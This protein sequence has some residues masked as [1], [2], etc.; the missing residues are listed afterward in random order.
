MSKGAWI[1]IVVVL[2]AG[3]LWWGL[4][5]HPGSPSPSMSSSA[6]P[7]A[8]AQGRAVLMITDPGT[9]SVQG[10]TSIMLTVDKVEVH[11][12]SQDW[13][14]VSTAAKQYDLLQLKQSG[15]AM[16][17]ADANLAAGT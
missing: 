6:S 7:M 4:G 15:A 5:S 1:G 14:T 13:V 17:L 3:G 2:V 11:S 8:N 16:L 9:G 10:A 12:A